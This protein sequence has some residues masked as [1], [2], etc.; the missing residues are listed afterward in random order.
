MDIWQEEVTLRFG[1]IDRSDRLTLG[2]VFGF[3]QEA[4]IS[5]A[6]VLGVGRDALNV[7][8]QAWVLSRLS[9]FVGQRPRYGETVT[10]RTWPRGAERLFALRDYD[11]ID[12]SG[13]TIVRA[14]SCWLVID[15]EKRKPLRIQPVIEKLPLNEGLDSLLSGPAVLEPRKDLKPLGKR[16]A[17]YSDIDYFGHVNNV[18]YVLWIQD[19]TPQNLLEDAGQMRLDINYI[20][21]TLANE[22]VEFFSSSFDHEPASP[23]CPDK[24]TAALAFE[25]LRPSSGHSVFRAEL[26]LGL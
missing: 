5:H 6:S 11:I 20:S 18:S 3:F 10:V 13:R 12:S 21:E 17:A 26:K 24:M 7:N 9:V 2:A 14:R 22:E 1:S 23:D 15:I 8:R 19:L 25:G 16:R 4:A